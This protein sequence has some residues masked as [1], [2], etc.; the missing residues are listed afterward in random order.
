MIPIASVLLGIVRDVRHAGV[1]LLWRSLWPLGA[2]DT[3]IVDPSE[4][5][6]RSERRTPHK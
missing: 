6:L 1:S 4:V 3:W 5:V 2:D